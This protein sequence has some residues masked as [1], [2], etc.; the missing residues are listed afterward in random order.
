MLKKRN[1]IFL[2]LLILVILLVSSCLPKAPVTVS[3][4]KGQV[5]VP[6]DSIKAKDLTGQALPDATVNII[7]LATGEV[8][9]TATTDSNGY[10]QMFVSA[11]GPYLLQAVKDGV[12]V[13]QFTPEVELGI[14]YDLGIAGCAT[15][16][17]ALIAQAMLEAEDYPD[18]PAD[19]NLTDIETNSDFD[20]V[21]SSVCDVLEAGGDPAESAFVLQA[22]E[23]FLHPPAP[24]PAPPMSSAKDII[25]YQFEAA[26]NV[27]ALSSDVIGIVDSGAHTIDLTVPYGTD[28]TALVATFELSASAT[29]KVGSTAQT[30]GITANDF[31]NSITYTVIAEDGSAQDWVVTVNVAIGPLDHF[32]ISGYP[33]SITAGENFDSNNII[34]TAYDGNNKIKTDY[35]G[36]VYFTSTDTSATLP[37]TSG[38]KYTFVAGDSGIH[39]FPGTGFTLFEHGSQYITLTDGTIS[40]MSQII[41][42]S[43]APLSYIVIEDDS[44]SEVTTH[45]MTT[46]DTYILYASGYDM[47]DNYIDVQ[48]VDWTGTGICEGKLSPTSGDSTTFTPTGAGTGTITADHATATDDTTGTIT[49]IIAYSVTYDGNG[50]TDGEVP[51]DSTHYQAGNTVTV[52]GNTEELEKVQDGISLLFTGWNTASDGNGTSYTEG[53]N[54]TM[55]NANV[56]LY[57]QW[58]ESAIGG[59][60]PA[61]GIVFYDK[62]SVSEGWRYL[63]AAPSDQSIGSFWGCEGTSIS[64]ADGTVVGTGKQNTLDIEAGC[65]TEGTAADIC[66]NLNLGDYDDWFLPSKDELDELY[67][68]KVVIGGFTGIYYW[69]STENNADYAYC[70]DFNTGSQ[71]LDYKDNFIGRYVRA[72]RAF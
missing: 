15:T 6:E 2:S 36:E 65:V 21:L 70:Q 68:K 14:E 31:T 66:A 4:L 49:V 57:A 60:G 23:D 58:S 39:T 67:H 28:L 1:L 44:E 22:I 18:D 61:G 12:K 11:G 17:S 29:A 27:T 30:S 64:G 25:S 37:Y 24:P 41:N 69:S 63:E 8:I 9:A 50:S 7:D 19:I 54:F 13:Q 71:A 34:I 43:T 16:A 35:I 3:I 55:G 10:Y 38:S 46:L 62:G 42:V 59:T 45:A 32:T 51:I 72:V 53:N 20:D 48:P 56:I 47:Y 40:R 5:M 52:L 33:T 26:K